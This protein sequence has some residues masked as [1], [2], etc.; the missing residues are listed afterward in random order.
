LGTYDLIESIELAYDRV[1]NTG[2]NAE[3]L[4]ISRKQA[5]DEAESDDAPETMRAV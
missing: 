3:F 2:A 5:R 4:D 1:H